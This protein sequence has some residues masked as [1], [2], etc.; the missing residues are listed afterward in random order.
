MY[1]LIRKTLEEC[2]LEACLAHDSQYVAIIK[3]SQWEREKDSFDLGIDMDMNLN[4]IHNTKVEVNIDSLTGTFLIP[5]RENMSGDGSRF[6]F[7]LDEKGIIFIDDSDTAQGIVEK[8]RKSRQ[9]Q[10]PC[11]ER[12]VYDFLEQIVHNDMRMM[13]KAEEELEEIEKTILDGADKAPLKHL[14]EIR[15]DIRK[16]RIHYEQL[17]D[18]SQELEENEN[19]FFKDDNLRYFHM[20]TN[21][22]ARLH[23]I[24]ASLRDYTVQ[25]GDLYQ[26][27]IDLKQNHI[28]TILTVV[29]AIFMPLT[30]I[31]GWYGMNF[32]YMPELDSP[33]GYPVV[34]GISIAIVVVCLI[35]FKKKNWL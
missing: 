33:L 20:F 6:A 11:L 18:L 32:K 22:M 10:Y 24:A 4:E 12:F 7:V 5:D 27:Q 2:S 28:M 17:I 21:R 35:I 23:D 1:Y 13:E 25:L 16:L 15:G 26:S 34:I 31:V 29:T 8:I 19:D 14:N 3:P 30:L 9:W